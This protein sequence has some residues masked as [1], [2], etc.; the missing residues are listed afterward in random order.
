MIS[1]V[2]ENYYDL[3]AVACIRE[4]GPIGARSV[5]VLTDR[6]QLI[7]NAGP[8]SDRTVIMVIQR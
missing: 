6:L 3:T 7:Y 5:L 1:V 4:P 8:K 2:N